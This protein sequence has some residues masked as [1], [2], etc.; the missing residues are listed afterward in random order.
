[1]F[2]KPPSRFHSPIRL[3]VLTVVCAIA[4]TLATAGVLA[5]RNARKISGGNNK[6]N[7]GNKTSHGIER[8]SGSVN[9]TTSGS[10]VQNP[11]TGETVGVPQTGEMG[12]QR[13]TAEIMSAQ[14]V[15]P[16]SSRPQI[17]PEREVEG[18][19]DRPQNPNAPA[20][21]SLPELE[22]ATRPASVVLNS[23]L[24]AAPQPVGTNFDAVTGPTETGAFPPDT[25]GA[26]GPSQ[27]FLFVNGRLRTLIRQPA[28][29]MV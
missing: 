21:A 29:L 4:F 25:M 19:D 26:V 17:L 13:T 22:G 8:T 6:A 7:S 12:V 10:N 28:S 27:F 14:A 2:K 1:M 20:V 18:R 16:P 11:V 15:A 5:Q 24:P 23:P 3:S 9:R